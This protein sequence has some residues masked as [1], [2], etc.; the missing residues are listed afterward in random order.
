VLLNSNGLNNK[1]RNISQAREM[2]WTEYSTQY[3]AD[4][5]SMFKALKVLL[6]TCLKLSKKQEINKDVIIHIKNLTDNFNQQKEKATGYYQ[7][8]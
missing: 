5:E 6:I 8:E 3:D 1:L 7:G 4:H 2:T